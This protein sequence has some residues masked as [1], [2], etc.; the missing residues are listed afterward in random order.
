MN[1]KSASNQPA[2]W[3]LVGREGVGEDRAQDWDSGI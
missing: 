3:E 2:V 1:R